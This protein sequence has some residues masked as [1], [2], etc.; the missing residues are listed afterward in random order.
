MGKSKRPWQRPEGWPS[1]PSEK[2]LEELNLRGRGASCHSNGKALCLLWSRFPEEFTLNARG[3]Q[4][5]LVLWTQTSC[6]DGAAGM[7]SWLGRVFYALAKLLLSVA[8]AVLLNLR[9]I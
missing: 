3:S 7:R 1:V 5:L 9:I 6:S 8:I 2:P 4:S